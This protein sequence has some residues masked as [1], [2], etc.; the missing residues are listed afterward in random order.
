MRDVHFSYRPVASD[1]FPEL[2]SAPGP[3]NE[4]TTYGPGTPGS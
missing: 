4:L 1:G 3:A 2:T